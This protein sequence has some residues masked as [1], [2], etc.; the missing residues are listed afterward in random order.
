MNAVLAGILQSRTVVGGDGREFPLRDEIS[1]AEGEF[2]QEVIGSRQLSRTLEIGCAFG[3][4]TLFICDAIAAVEGASHTV[5]DRYQFNTKTPTSPGYDGIGAL[6]V[7]RAGHKNIV[8]FLA[9][10][11]Y[12]GLPKL[13]AEQA[14]FDFAFI[15]GMH[16]FD[17]ALVDFFYADLLL[18]VGGVIAFDDVHMP[19][20]RRVCRYALRNRQYRVV[21][22]AAGPVSP[23]RQVASRLGTRFARLRQLMSHDM[24]VPDESMGLPSNARYVALEKL[25]DD[26]IGNSDKYARRWNAHQDF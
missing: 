19:A 20:V 11:S 12:S 15:D 25:G 24:L 1:Q 9:E 22:P 16:T 6:N 13:V 2:L 3:V 7:E 21:A 17:Y 18:E 14:R 26:T 23:K 5:I 4:S 8:R 10:P